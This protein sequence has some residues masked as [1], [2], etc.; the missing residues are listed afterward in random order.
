M[1]NL[2][3]QQVINH[4]YSSL[5]N[6]L[7]EAHESMVSLSPANDELKQYVEVFKRV[8][9][10][11][12]EET[13]KRIE[14]IQTLMVWDH[15]VIAFFGSTNA[16]K[17]TIIETLRLK[18]EQNKGDADGEIVGTGEPD[19]TERFGEYDLSIY[20]KKITLIDMPGILNNKE[21]YKDQIL[22]ALNK[23][24]LVFYVDRDD[25]KPDE[26][27]VKKIQ[28]YLKDWVKVYTIY[29]V[30]GFKVNKD[31]LQNKNVRDSACIKEKG[32][33]EALG[34]CYAGNITLHALFALA[35]IANFPSYREDLIR[36]KTNCLKKFDSCE[37]MFSYSEFSSLVNLL[38]DQIENYK[39]EIY[40]ANMQRCTA[41]RIMTIRCL[42]E[43]L[44][45]NL[46]K[47]RE[48]P[49]ELKKFR[50]DVCRYYDTA[51]SNIQSSCY[52]IIKNNVNLLNVECKKLVEKGEK[53][54][55]KRCAELQER[56]FHLIAN[57]QKQK[58]SDI[59]KQLSSDI[60]Q[61]KKKLENFMP[62]LNMQVSY[63]SGQARI[64]FQGAA[65]CVEFN[66]ENVMDILGDI[67]A[68][69][70]IGSPAGLWGMVLFGLGGLGKG[71]Y[72]SFWGD[73]YKKKAKAA[74]EKAMN[75]LEKELQKSSKQS[76]EMIV[77]KIIEQRDKN[78]TAIDDE[79][80]KVSQA[81]KTIETTCRR[82]TS[83]E[84]D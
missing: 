59:I 21:K 41:I 32:Y 22:N 23:A 28:A 50:N 79:I 19:F 69:M 84:K 46:Q 10:K 80:K 76:V 51:V 16:G 48:I 71:L 61:R 35:S 45:I 82:L 57:E 75:Q 49:I 54:L 8:L 56:C 55:D 12:I 11:S 63:N 31:S 67:A 72:D 36:K 18:Y 40:L 6:L 17:S 43:E 20:D 13:R 47:Q 30:S 39:D 4:C 34:N 26:K 27:T 83:L 15:L 14:E 62:Q 52:S 2:A 64:D 74:I 5:L 37:E 1:N 3:H 66:F 65:N 73:S 68:G 29:N 78:L 58:V 60:E 9:M 38:V 70:V 25:T 33:A 44:E 77:S 53:E 42:S 24:H 81:V 7:N